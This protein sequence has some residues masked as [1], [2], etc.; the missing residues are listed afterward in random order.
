MEEVS[1]TVDNQPRQQ[2][3]LPISLCLKINE[4]LAPD[5]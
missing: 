4:F 3:K 5:Q 2:A 1:V